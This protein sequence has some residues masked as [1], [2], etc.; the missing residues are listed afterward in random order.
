MAGKHRSFLRDHKFTVT[1]FIVLYSVAMAIA[2]PM[3]YG[4]IWLMSPF[5]GVA[6]PVDAVV[7]LIVLAFLLSTASGLRI[8]LMVVR[9]KARGRSHPK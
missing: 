3:F 9:R 8:A 6:A 5:I 7:V 1:D 2:L 4:L